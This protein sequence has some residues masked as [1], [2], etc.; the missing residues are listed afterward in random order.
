MIENR[1]SKVKNL[2]ELN[3][4]EVV[5]VEHLRE[6]LLSDKKLRVKL[7]IDP[8]APDLHLGHAVILRKLREFQ[9]LGHKI[10]FIIGDFTGKIGDPSGRTETRKPLTDFEV[11]KNMKSYL[12]QAGKVINIKKTEIFYNSQWFKKEGIQ[13]LIEL[14]MA[15][16]IQQVLKRAD[17][18]KRMEE[19]NEITL[20]E[21]LYPLL[22]GYDSLKVRADVEIGGTDQKFNLLMGRRV[23]RYF[24]MKEQDVVMIPLLEGLDGVK[25]MSKSFGNYIGLADSANDMFGKIMSLPDQMI[26]K[27][28]VFCTD[29]NESEIVSLEKELT[30]KSLKEKLAFEIVKIYHGEKEALKTKDN[31]LKVFSKKDLSGE[32]PVLKVENKIIAEDLV[33]KTGV[34]GSKAKAWRLITQGGFSIDSKAIKNPKEKIVFKGGEVAKIGKKSFFR[35][36]V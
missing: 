1:E 2:L 10:V 12:A 13:K 31:F 34:A 4:Q 19:D 6:A 30:P 29:L 28:F 18:K 8:T 22:Q 24:G 26:R 9:E 7:G 16:T 11:K 3:V 14:S 32:L 33:L 27:Y 35:I 23:Q 25:K 21:I 17:F 5:D 20:L 36:K 15:S